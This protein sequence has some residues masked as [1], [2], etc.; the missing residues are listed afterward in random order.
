MSR[1]Q[2]KARTYRELGWIWVLPSTA[3]IIFWVKI[4]S[5]YIEPSAV[6]EQEHWEHFITWHRL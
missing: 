1:G 2:Y 5:K 6:V 3:A 4:P